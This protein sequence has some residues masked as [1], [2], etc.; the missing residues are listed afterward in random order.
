MT[1]RPLLLGLATAFV[2]Y[3]QDSVDLSVV[4]RIKAEAFEN[5]KIMDHLFY[6]TDVHGP[7]LAGSPQYKEAGDW[8]VSRLKEYGLT[9]V[10]EEPW[11]PFGR[12]WTYTHFEG[13]LLEPQYAPIIGFP[14]AWTP[15]TNGAVYGRTDARRC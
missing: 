2:L 8:V 9:N 10:H 13:H 1:L 7:R 12:G 6:L 4:H 3:P 5:S 15:G 14:L 11:G